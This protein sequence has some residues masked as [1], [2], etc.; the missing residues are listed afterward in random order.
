MVE[1]VWCF[2]A[3]AAVPLGWGG[4]PA[5]ARSEG[6]PHTT[7]SGAEGKEAATTKK[8][9]APSSTANEGTIQTSSTTLVFCFI[10]FRFR[11]DE[12]NLRMFTKLDVC[13][14]NTETM[15]IFTR[16]TYFYN[17]TADIAPRVLQVIIV[18]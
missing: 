2:D 5:L 3:Q 7:P 4:A 17:S 9:V 10:S 16:I 6:R 18:A 8:T 11:K 12:R 1:G 15:I 14:N 13:N